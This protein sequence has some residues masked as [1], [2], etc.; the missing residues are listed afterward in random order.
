MKAKHELTKKYK[1]K[2]MIENF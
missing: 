1:P 2:I